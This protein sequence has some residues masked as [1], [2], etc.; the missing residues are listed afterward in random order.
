MNRYPWQSYLDTINALI[1]KVQAGMNRSGIW[2]RATVEQSLSTA[3]RNVAALSSNVWQITNDE[4]WGAWSESAGATVASLDQALRYLG[5]Y[6]ASGVASTIASNL[7]NTAVSVATGAGE[8]VKTGLAVGTGML[9]L[10]VAVV[11]VVKLS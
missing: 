2:N 3:L 1:M 11:L 8:A 7:G 4:Y 9:V 6:S 10:L 5:D